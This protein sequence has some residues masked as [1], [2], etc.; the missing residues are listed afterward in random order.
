[1]NF[2]ALSYWDIGL[3]SLLL[4]FNAGLSWRLRLGLEKRLVVAGTR[5]VVQLTL[6]G[7]VLKALFAVASPTFKKEPTSKDYYPVMP[8]GEPKMP[9]LDSLPAM[10]ADRFDRRLRHVV[11]KR[12]VGLPDLHRVF[13]I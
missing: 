8:H 9:A 6:V 10:T 12:R 2:I 13:S 5:M 11:R 3:A 1:M 7:L 4:V